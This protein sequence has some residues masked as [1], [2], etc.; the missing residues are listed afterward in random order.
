MSDRV[1]YAKPG[2]D[3]TG[4]RSGK[5]V[6]VRQLSQKTKSGAFFWECLCDCGK[7]HS[8]SISHITRQKSR[9]CG[10]SPVNGK[11]GTHHKSRASEYRAWQAMKDRCCNPSAQSFHHYGG[12]G[13]S[14][15]D[16]WLE[17]FENFYADMGPRP[18]PSLSLDR[19]NNDGP[20]APDNCRWATRIEQANNRRRPRART[21]KV[22]T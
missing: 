13:I 12:R 19:I 1:K 17:S 9:H 7:T 10:C 18:S 5:L 4:T 11:A 2:R 3:I 20:Y 6:A 22:K 8:V 15:C 14:V 21:R 16:R